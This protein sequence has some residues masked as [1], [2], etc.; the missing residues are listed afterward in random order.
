MFEPNSVQIHQVDDENFYRM[1]ENF[2]L[3]ATGKVKK[4]KS[5]GFVLWVL[6]MSMQHFMS[7]H[8]RAVA[9]FQSG[10]KWANTTTLP[11]LEPL[12]TFLCSLNCKHKKVIG[13]NFLLMAAS[14]S[15]LSFSKH[16]ATYGNYKF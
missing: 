16:I 5:L 10:L 4:S 9:I 6:F 11:S 12:K 2:G 13:I 14:E 8:P 1:N 3:C 7:I 15:V